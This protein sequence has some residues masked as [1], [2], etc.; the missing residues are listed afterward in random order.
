M[1]RSDMESQSQ[2]TACWL[3]MGRKLQGRVQ[4]ASQ[5]AEVRLLFPR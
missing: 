4:E 1:D 5:G 2:Q 3:D